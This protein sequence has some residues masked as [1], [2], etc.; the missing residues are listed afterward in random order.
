[1]NSHVV[2]KV[3]RFARAAALAVLCIAGGVGL[4]AVAA[5]AQDRQLTGRVVDADGNAPVPGAAVTIVGTALGTITNDSGVFHIRVPGAAVVVNARRIGFTPRNVPVAADQADV[6]IGLIKD[7]LELEATVVTGTATSISSRNAANAVTVLNADQINQVPSSTLDD[8]MQGKIPGAIIQQNNGGAPGG[9]MQ[10]QIRGVTSINSDASALYVIDGVPVNNGHINDGANAISG[11]NDNTITQS[12][13]D[14]PPNRIADI[15]PEDIESIEILKG[16]SAAAQ[17]GSRAGGGVVLIT[18][19][20][21]TPGKAKWDLTGKVGTFTPSNSLN[22]RSFPTAASAEAWY[23]AYKATPSTPWN[24]A[25]YQGNNDMQSQVF[26]GGEPSYEGDLSVRGQSG[27]TQY[28]ASLLSKYDNG[29]ML[30]TGYNKQGGRVNL[31][32]SFSEA[33]TGNL[34]MYFA[35]SDD[36][37]GITGN[38]NVGISPYDVFSVTPAFFNQTLRTSTGAYQTNPYGLANAYQDAALIQT[39]EEVSRF[40]GG[41]NVDARIFQTDRQS[42]H[43]TALAGA[44]IAHQTDVFYAPPDIQIETN[45]PLPG[46]ATNLSGDNTYLN[47]NVNLV[48]HYAGG[49]NF[50]ATTSIGIGRDQRYLYNPYSVGQELPP[51]IAQVTAGAVQHNYDT[52]VVSRTFD[53]YAQEQFLTL[54]QRLALSAGITAERATDNG[55]INTYYPYPKFS[56]SFRVPQFAG[57]L[58]ELKLRGAWGRSGTDPIFGVRYANVDNLTPQL[59]QGVTGLT[60]PLSSNDPG[61]KPETNTEIETGFDA[62]MLSSRAQFSF[63]IYQKRIT[64]LL[65]QAGVVSSSGNTSQWLNGGQFTDRGIEL[66]LQLTPIQMAK[67][68]TWIFT[69]TFYRNY[70][71]MDELPVPAFSPATAFGPAFGQYWIQTGRSLTEFVNEN[72]SCGNGCYQQTGDVAPSYTMSFGNTFTLARFHLYGLLDWQRGGNIGNLTNAYFDP[73]GLFLLADSALEAKR[74][75]VNNAGGP[76]YVESASFVKLR[77]VTLSYALPDRWVTGL[78]WLRL[79]SARLQ[80]SGRNLWSSFPYTGLDPEVSNFGTQN[81]GRG[82]DV[83]PYPPSRSVFFSL[84]LGF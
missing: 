49:N 3:P 44:D 64:D 41:G 47:Y 42:L 23:N 54:D 80:V 78:G 62:T 31:T 76:A 67:G 1:V 51:G 28:Y 22:L 26:G 81:I 8:A 4:T 61:I 73:N 7:V 52:T 50:D 46:V 58:D 14:N 36:R 83:T 21:G 5:S 33:I 19:K 20:K 25:L 60:T 82:Q 55:F 71:V 35:H 77:E 68:L 53:F 74:N 2:G 69:S 17:Y 65:L 11:A 10:I 30:N 18:T 13:Q 34:N 57:F 48:H 59:D 24:A 39:P 43:L 12:S 27:Q 38:D 29:L 79:A 56:A 45:Q 40:I 66:S 63:T 9:G 32:Q 16:A 37:R 15:N 70:S 84:D 75:A 6:T 72:N